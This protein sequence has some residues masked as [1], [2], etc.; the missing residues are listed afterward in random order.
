MTV[1]QIFLSGEAVYPVHPEPLPSI[2][3]IERAGSLSVFQDAFLKTLDVPL[4]G[5]YDWS[6]GI[7]QPFTKKE[8]ALVLAQNPLG[9]SVLIACHAGA[10][11]FVRHFDQSAEEGIDETKRYMMRF[12]VTDLE[13][14]EL[15]HAPDPWPV[16]RSRKLKLP[17]V[18]KL[19]LQYYR[20]HLVKKGRV[21][22]IA[23][24]LG[25]SAW[26]AVSLGQTYRAVQ[27]LEETMPVVPE[28]TL[29]Q[30]EKLAQLIVLSE[31][32]FPL[33]DVLEVVRALLPPEI[34][35]L[36]MAWQERELALELALASPEV[37]PV[38]VE[39][40]RGALPTY[41]VASTQT[42]VTIKR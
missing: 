27:K 32:L 12:G 10:I 24:S 2:L 11:L 33:K 18:K 7:I 38:W 42:T 9:E 37:L 19:E 15:V 36:N 25:V 3:Y 8:W 22:V 40:L 13:A 31:T 34:V 39:Q 26:Q 1:Q 14:I 21:G 28:S 30:E 41:Q 29:P 20:Y 6:E 16:H 4:K 17:G 5:V 23:A 35:V